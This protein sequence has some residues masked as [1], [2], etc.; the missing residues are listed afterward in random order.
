LLTTI[1]GKSIITKDNT[2]AI[3]KQALEGFNDD[4]DMATG[5]ADGGPVLD[6]N[7][8]VTTNIKYHPQYRATDAAA[9]ARWERTQH[10]SWTLYEEIGKGDDKKLRPILDDISTAE[11]IYD[12]ARAHR[13]DLYTMLK[14]GQLAEY[15]KSAPPIDLQSKV[16]EYI[17]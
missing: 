12:F 15:N 16:D 11:S 6:E 8:K 9:K 17:N 1:S 7:D 14:F 10:A 4:L 13:N 5:S 3:Q 2:W